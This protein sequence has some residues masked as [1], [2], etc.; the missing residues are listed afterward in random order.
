MVLIGGTS[1][2]S[3]PIAFSKGDGS[4][5]VMH[6]E[7]SQLAR[8]GSVRNTKLLV[9]DFNA[10][11]AADISVIGGYGWKTVPIGF[12]LG[13]TEHKYDQ[14]A[15]QLKSGVYNVRIGSQPRKVKISAKDGGGW[16]EVLRKKNG[17]IVT[18]LKPSLVNRLFDKPSN[19]LIKYEIDGKTY[20]VYK[21]KTML[22]SFKPYS[23][24]VQT[25]SSRNNVLNRDFELYSSFADAAA[26]R[27]KWQFCNYDDNGVGFPRDCGPTKPV[28]GRWT[29]WG[30][31]GQRNVA[32]Y[33]RDG[34]LAAK[35]V[36]A[37]QQQ[38]KRKAEREKKIQSIPRGVYPLQ[39]GSD[40]RDLLV[41]NS[42]NGGGWVLILRKSFG[43]VMTDVGRKFINR[44][45][46]KHSDGLIMY[47]VEGKL[48]AVYKRLRNRGSFEP[49]DY[50]VNTWRSRNNVLN[51][52]FELYSSMNDAMARRNKWQACNYD[53]PGVGF[54][55][56]CGTTKLTSGKWTSW[57]RG[58]QTNVAFYIHA[59]KLVAELV[60]PKHAKFEGSFQARIG[61]S[62]NWRAYGSG[63]RAPL[64]TRRGNLCMLGGLVSAASVLSANPLTTLPHSCRPNKRLIFNVNNHENT[65]RVDVLANG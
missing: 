54:P 20:A 57:K 43:K 44:L 40:K 62:R 14:L 27:N 2:K 7:Q 48:Y 26:G 24:L 55:R 35:L 47:Q 16:V 11:G 45:F 59:P 56:D 12:S 28:G 30:R 65:L 32:F 42:I 34:R 10:D 64:L 46:Q 61:L 15:S 36:V 58:G 19:M 6:K 37:Q 60:K 22:L 49:Y 50:L 52:D 33:I 25:W 18:D 17:R 8:D 4:F 5:K 1:W 39:I 9:A 51:K 13:P 31:G 29:S 53:V 21:R 41:D 38:A 23:Y 63:Y 3:L